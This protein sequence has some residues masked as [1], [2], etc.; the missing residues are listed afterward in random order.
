VPSLVA[1]EL[2]LITSSVALELSLVTSLVTLALWLVEHQLHCYN[3]PLLPK[4]PKSFPFM[5]VAP[6]IPIYSAGL[7]A[8][9]IT[10]EQRSAVCC[11]LLD[12]HKTRQ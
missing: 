10:A 1:L 6:H 5:S 9:S 11:E 2:Q 12:T 4:L 8:V 3:L 7:S